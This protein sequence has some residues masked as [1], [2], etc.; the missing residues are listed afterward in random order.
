MA[1]Y[2]SLYSW[3]FWPTVSCDERSHY[4]ILINGDGGG[5]FEG[6]GASFFGLGIGRFLRLLPQEVAVG[7]GIASKRGRRRIRDHKP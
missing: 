6:F 2:F 7:R 1:Q 5:R 3:L 4:L